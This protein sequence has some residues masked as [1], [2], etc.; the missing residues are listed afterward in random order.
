M[1]SI[2]ENEKIITDQK[3]RISKVMG[4]SIIRDFVMKW[5]ASFG[6]DSKNIGAADSVISSCWI[7]L[8]TRRSDF[9]I[10]ANGQKFAMKIDRSPKIKNR[11]WRL[12]VI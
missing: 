11:F 8:A 6:I 5:T 12:V 1:A 4:L 3:G 7:I 10:S 2:D 9:A